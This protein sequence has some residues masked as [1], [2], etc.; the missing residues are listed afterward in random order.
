MANRVAEVNK[1]LK[2]MGV[3]E[4]LVRGNGYYYFFGGEASSWP[5]SSVA[6]F[7]ADELSVERWIK[8]YDLLKNARDNYSMESYLKGFKEYINEAN[9]DPQTTG[10]DIW[11]HGTS[12]ANLDSIRREGIKP[13]GN[14]GAYQWAVDYAKN[15]AV[16]KRMPKPDGQHVYVTQDMKEASF[17]ATLS[18][19]EV[20]GS[21]IIIKVQLPHNPSHD[22]ADYEGYEYPGPIPP[23]DCLGWIE[24]EPTMTPDE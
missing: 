3:P 7:R 20:G 5:N 22:P 15:R 21:P 23:S 9:V 6:V 16:V 14:K 19:K 17:Y 10:K 12:D 1:V 4:R 24:A 8:E 11:F 2:A 13:R 18:T